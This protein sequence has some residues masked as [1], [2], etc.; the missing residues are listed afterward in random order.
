MASMNGMRI[1]REE[2]FGPVLS[3]VTVEDEEEALK[4]ANDTNYGLAASLYTD[5]F[6]RAH[7]MARSIRAGTVPVDLDSASLV[8]SGAGNTSTFGCSYGND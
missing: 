8:S 2:I 6:N 4:V 7:R 5:G 1:T 3:V